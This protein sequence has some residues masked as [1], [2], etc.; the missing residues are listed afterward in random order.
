M[1]VGVGFVFIEKYRDVVLYD[2]CNHFSLRP[3]DVTAD[4]AWLAAVPF[5]P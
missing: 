5:C 3:F 4:S 2:I 1:D